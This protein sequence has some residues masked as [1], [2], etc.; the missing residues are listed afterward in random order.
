MATKLTIIIC[1]YNRGYLLSKTLPTIFQ[2]DVSHNDYSVLIVNNNSTDNTDKILIEFAQQYRNISIVHEPKQGLSIAKN[3]GAFNAKSDWLIFLDD[4]AKVPK[5]FI[6]IALKNINYQNIVCFGG[7]YLPWYKYGKPNW[8]LDEYVSNKR[9]ISNFTTL[10]KGFISGGIMAIKKSVLTELGG[11][12]TKIGMRGQK[13]GYGE[14]NHLQIKLREA[15]FQ[16]GYD[17]NWIIYHLVNRYKLSPW[18]FIRS[19]FASGRD[20]YEIY[21]KTNSIMIIGKNFY[22]AVKFFMM[23][24]FKFTPNLIQ[25]N[26][27]RQNWLIDVLKP[28]AILCGQ[29]YSGI[30]QLFKN[31]DK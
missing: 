8:F 13:I 1:T 6:N 7:V 12:P 9:K 19:G 28:S 2:Q 4:D 3:T 18:W 22:R 5:D 21:N 26:Y 10:K 20:T 11:F 16:I 23:N 17:P 29:I 30:M 15:G 27:R 25:E 24:I 31:D 14:E